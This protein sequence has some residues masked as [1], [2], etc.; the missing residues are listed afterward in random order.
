MYGIRELHIHKAQKRQMF[1]VKDESCKNTRMLF[2]SVLI[3]SEAT[4]TESSYAY[5]SYLLDP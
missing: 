2:T 4:A 3:W 1:Y 5:Q